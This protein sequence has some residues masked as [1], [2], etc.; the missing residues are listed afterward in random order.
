M[1]KRYYISDLKSGIKVNI[2]Y[3]AEILIIK[4]KMGDLH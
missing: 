4:Y 2:I 1:R 3:M